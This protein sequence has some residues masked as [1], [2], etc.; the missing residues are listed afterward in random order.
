MKITDILFLDTIVIDLKIDNKEELL[1]EMVKIASKTG[2]INDIDKTVDHIF[3]RESIMSTGVGK[4]IALPHAKSSAVTDPLGVLT[5]LK[6]P[7]DFKALDDN[8]V[9]IVFMLL[10]KENNIGMHLRLLSKISRLLNNDS[11]RE[12]IITSDSPEEI[13][14]I[15]VAHDEVK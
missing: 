13:L 10:G 7:I 1:K 12:N 6:D 2:K 8:K 15:L 9:N 3:E 11:I 5:I 4:G 14:E